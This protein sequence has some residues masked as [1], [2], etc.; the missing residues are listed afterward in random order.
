MNPALSA[1]VRALH[2]L[3]LPD[4]QGYLRLCTVIYYV[5]RY[6]TTTTH[7]EESIVFLLR[8][9]VPARLSVDAPD[10]DTSVL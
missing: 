2:E 4:S 1:I 9:A 5:I 7:P 6:C 10:T 8:S 3:Q